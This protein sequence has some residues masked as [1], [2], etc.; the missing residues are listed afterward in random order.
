MEAWRLVRNPHTRRV[1]EA[2]K[3]AGVTATRMYEYVAEG[4]P[5]ARDPPPGVG[6]AVHDPGDPA[7]LDHAHA[8]ERRPDEYAVVARVDGAPVGHLFASVDATHRIDP[9][10]RSLDVDGAY[11]RRVWVG[12]SCRGEGVASALLARALRATAADRTTALVA[13][14]NRAS[15]RLFAGTGFVAR[16]AHTYVRLGPVALRRTTPVNV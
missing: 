9:L 1:Y 7:T 12:P 10:E 16:R 14:D 15:R 6:V 5:E 2:L 3:R 4:T 8:A 11:V 13:V